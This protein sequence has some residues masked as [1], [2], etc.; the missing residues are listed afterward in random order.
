[1]DFKAEQDIGHIFLYGLANIYILR[2][3]AWLCT[4]RTNYHRQKQL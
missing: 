3:I 2:A 4:E 1:M